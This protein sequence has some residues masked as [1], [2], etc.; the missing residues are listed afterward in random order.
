MTR[1]EKALVVLVV[2]FSIVVITTLGSGIYMWTYP[3]PWGWLGIEKQ[4]VGKGVIFSEP[5]VTGDYYIV[6]V[7]M[8]PRRNVT[9]CTY[10]TELGGKLEIGQEITL[11]RFVNERDIPVHAG[12][13][14]EPNE[15]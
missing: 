15:N 9:A 5:I 13:F 10:P 4:T 7:F 6:P 3:K 11:V 1:N 8:L 2:L 12:L 14:C